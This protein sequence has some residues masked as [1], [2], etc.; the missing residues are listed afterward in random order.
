MSTYWKYCKETFPDLIALWDSDGTSYN[1]MAG[2][3]ITSHSDYVSIDGIN[4]GAM[5]GG[6]KG[7]LYTV[8]S[9]YTTETDLLVEFAKLMK[10]W[11]EIGVWPTDVLNN[12]SMTESMNADMYR[13]GQ[14]AAVQKHT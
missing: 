7:D 8:Y 5:W 14:V 1:A 9:P 10:E 2:G 13:V 3:W 12:T 11:D 6:K 4:A